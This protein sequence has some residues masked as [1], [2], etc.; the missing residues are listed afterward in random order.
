MPATATHPL[1]FR[2]NT[3][4]IYRAELDGL[5]YDISRHGSSWVLRVRKLTETAGVTHALGQPVIDADR[6]DRLGDCKAVAQEY[7]ALAD[8]YRTDSSPAIHGHKS[9]MTT[10]ICKAYARL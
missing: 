7:H 8:D 4:G 6:A 2:R 3:E 1:T 10:A 9:R 5:R